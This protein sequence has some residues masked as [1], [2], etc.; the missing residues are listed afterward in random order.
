[1][2]LWFARSSTS[3]LFESTAISSRTA[4]TT[5]RSSSHLELLGEHRQK[6]H[7]LWLLQQ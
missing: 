5:A 3:K 4:L 7:R 2:L 6:H 1:M